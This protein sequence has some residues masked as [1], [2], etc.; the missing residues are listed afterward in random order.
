[1]RHEPSVG[2]HLPA[3]SVD[4]QSA[5]ERRWS[6]ADLP[7]HVPRQS[8]GRLGQGQDEGEDREPRFHF[9]F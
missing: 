6:D 5:I 2:Q 7:V 3:V 8:T 9:N 4:D 1:M